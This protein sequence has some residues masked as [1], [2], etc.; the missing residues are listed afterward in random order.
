VWLFDRGDDVKVLRVQPL[1]G[2]VLLLSVV[3]CGSKRPYIP[4]AAP[5]QQTVEP[6]PPAPS[7][8]PDA[9]PPTA[10]T[11]TEEEIFARK[12]LEDLNAEKHLAPVFFELDSATVPTSYGDLLQKNAE[13]L[14]R[15]PSVRVTIEGHCDARGTSEYNLALGDRRARSVVSY[16][17]GLG[18]AGDR[19]TPVSKGKE[20]PTCSEQS[21]SC[22]Q[23]NRRGHFIITA[24]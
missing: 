19:L 17:T 12:T 14:K 13:W 8:P 20:Q 21:E 15:W 6:A 24:K 7:P 11:E 10:I 22:W 23:R 4:P 5:P 9:P 16:L 18:V 3:G 1:L 2:V